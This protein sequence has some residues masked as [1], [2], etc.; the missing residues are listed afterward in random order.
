MIIAAAT[1]YGGR[2]AD[3]MRLY[4]KS[5]GPKVVRGGFY[6][7]F[8][9]SLERTMDGVL[10]RAKDFARKQPLDLPPLLADHARDWHIFDSETVKL[11]DE[12]KDEYPGTGDYAA[13]KVHKR[14]SVGTGTVYDYH[15]SPARDHDAPHLVPDESWRGLGLLVDLGYASLQ[16]VSDCERYAMP[17][18]MRLKES[19]KPK[20]NRITRGHVSRT[21][22]PGTDFDALLDSEVILLAGNVVDAQVTIGSGSRQVRCRLVGVPAPDGAYRFYLSNLPPTVGPRQISDIY[23][24][25]WEIE[26]DNKLD[27]S[28]HHLDEVAA[29]TGPAARALV[30]ASLVSSM[31]ACFIAHR[32]RLK[33]KRPSRPGTERKVAPIHPQAL[34]RAMGCAA[35]DIA[36]AF[37]MA[38]VE[39]RRKW[40]DIAEYLQHLGKDP[41]WRR[42]P[43]IL[44]QLRGW[45]ITPGRPKSARLASSTR[46][47]AN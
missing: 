14:F 47:R 13:L 36:N 21:F 40:T 4:F 10:A 23:R 22:F 29:E 2:Q 15:L 35:L 12:L 39:A 11:P 8:G 26:S 20:V 44:D 25:R 41:N 30:H 9:P 42:S 18:V 38:G 31:L 17:F 1:G 7:W 27:K 28:C 43:S 24:V 32:Y 19:W 6:A 45:K 5:G 37:E 34:A 33:E 46:N 16:L 3:V